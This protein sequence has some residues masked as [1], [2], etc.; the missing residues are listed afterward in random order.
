MGTGLAGLLTLT[1]ACGG[2]ETSISHDM[3]TSAIESHLV[4]HTENLDRDLAFLDGDLRLFE[5]LGFFTSAQCGEEVHDEFGHVIGLEE[6]PDPE[7]IRINFAEQRTELVD[8]INQFLSESSIESQ[9]DDHIV[10]RISTETVCVIPEEEQQ[11]IGSDELARMEAD[12]RDRFDYAQPR[13]AVSREDSRYTFELQIGSRALNPIDLILTPG[14]AELSI[15]LPSAREAIKEQFEYQSEGDTPIL[16]DVSS[17]VI[18]IA[19]NTGSVGSPLVRF[20]IDEDI[21]IRSEDDDLAVDLGRASPFA[22]VNVDTAQKTIAAAISGGSL[23][24]IIKTLMGAEEDEAGELVGGTERQ[25]GLELAGLDFN[26]AIGLG[27]NITRTLGFG[28]GDATSKLY[29][30]GQQVVAIDIDPSNDRRIAIDVNRTGDQGENFILGFTDPRNDLQ[31]R[32]TFLQIEDL[33]MPDWMIKEVIKVSLNAV[34]DALPAIEITPE[35]MIPQAAELHIISE[36]AGVDLVVG[37]GE[38]LVVDE[39]IEEGN[40]HPLR[41]MVTTNICI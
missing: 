37:A 25:I 34:G 27:E 10:Y 29:I 9:D 40:G 14:L 36:S 23:S 26:A 4:A 6:C 12:C 32:T 35:N 17:G 33:E 22:S 15:D 2:N 1:T 20:N 3:A 21:V 31:V 41:Q 39:S 5:E 11:A 30:D 18:S 16:P 8:L 7:P 13:I 24:A 19:L 28:L 38:C